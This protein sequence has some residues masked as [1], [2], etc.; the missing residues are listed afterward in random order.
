[1]NNIENGR[2]RTEQENVDAVIFIMFLI[3]IAF[4]GRYSEMNLIKLN[5]L[6]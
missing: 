1:M 4:V 3:F 6:L 2:E 5:T